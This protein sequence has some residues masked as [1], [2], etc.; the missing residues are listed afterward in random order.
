MPTSTASTTTIAATDTT[1]PATPGKPAFAHIPDQDY[2]VATPLERLKFT[3]YAEAG[4]TV[5]LYDHGNIK[6]GEQQ[7]DIFGRWFIETAKVGEGAHAITMTVTDQ[8]GNVSSHSD[9]R[10]IQ[11]RTHYDTP[12]APPQ[13][14]ALSD[15]GAS[16][17]D[18]ISNSTAPSFIGTAPP[19]TRVQ[20]YV[21]GVLGGSAIVNALGKWTLYDVDMSDGQHS[22]TFVVRD[23]SAITSP[24]SPPLI[25]TVDTSIP[26]ADVPRLAPGTASET[27]DGHEI[28][29]TQTATITGNTEAGAQVKLYLKSFVV[30]TATA[31]ANGDWSVEIAH[32]ND[33]DHR[34]TTQAMDAAGNMDWSPQQALLL[35]VDTGAPKLATPANSGTAGQV[36][37]VT[38]PTVTGTA[39]A[40]A[41]VE[42]YDGATVVGTGVADANGAWSIVASVLSEGQHSLV[43][44]FTNTN[45]QVQQ[46][47]GTLMVTVK[48]T[49]A[50]PSAPT[51]DIR[52][53]SGTSATDN[54]TND[55][56]QLLRGTSEPG[57]YIRVYDG[58][59]AIQWLVADADGNWNSGELVR[60]THGVHQLSVVSTDLAGN[61]SPRS[62]VTTITIDTQAP[63]TPAAPRLDASSD[64]GASQADHLTNI[65][66]PQVTG[67]AEAGATVQLF[68]DGNLVGTT[69]ADGSGAWSITSS[70]L[71]DGQH[72]LTAFASDAAGNISAVSD[73][74]AINIDRIAL[75]APTRLALAPSADG[76]APA[77]GQLTDATPA[78]TGQGP[79]GATV[80]LLDGSVQVGTGVAD[81]AGNWSIV[82]GALAD[83]VHRL[84]ASTVDAA[85]NVSVPSGELL[86]T[87]ATWAAPAA[88]VLAASSDSGRSN[89]DGITH[90]TTPTVNGTTK[91]GASVTLFDGDT[92]VGAAQADAAGAWSITSTALAAGAHN[93]T[94]KVSDSAGNVS[95]AS[96]ALAITID[97][98]GPSAPGAPDLAAGADGGGS[99]VD[100]VTNVALPVVGGKAEAHAS[101]SLYD[102]ATRLGGAIAD[103]DG[104][105]LITSTVALA[106]GVHSLTVKAV[107]VAGNQ[108]AAS[109]ALSVTIDTAALAAPS[110]LDL[111]A[112]SDKGISNTDNVTSVAAPAISGKAAAGSVV[113]VYDGANALGKVVANASGVWSLAAGTLADGVHQLTATATDLAGNVSAPSAALAVTIDTARPDVDQPLLDA[114]SDSGH[115]TTDGITNVTT[116]TLRGTTEAGATV[117]LLDGATQVGSAVADAAGAW[118]ITSKALAAG[119]HNLA[120]KATDIAGNVSITS[121]ALALTIDNRGPTAPTTLDL[122]AGADS[123]SSALDNIT[124][125]TLPVVGGKAEAYAVVALYDGAQLLGNTVADAA[126]NWQIVSTVA[127]ADGARSLTA[128]TTDTAGNV[129]AASVALRVTIDTGAPAAPSAL[130]LAAVSDKGASNTDNVTSVTTPTIGGKAAAGSTVVLFDGAH[131]IGKAVANAAGTW[132]IASPKLEDGEHR[133]TATATDLAGNTSAPSTALSVTIDTDAPMPGIPGLDARSD[134]GLRD[135]ITNINRPTFKGDGEAGT[136]VT[137]FD[138][139]RQV[140]SAVVD[141]GGAWS[142]T[143]T[144]LA[145]G[146]HTMTAKG[147]DAAGNVSVVMPGWELRMSIDTKAPVAPTVLDLVAGADSGASSSDN[148]SAVTLPVLTGKAEGFSTVSVYDGATLLGSAKADSA[149]AWTVATTVALAKGVHNLTA[150]ATDSTGNTSAASAALK[151]TID[152]AATGLTL[153]GGV[154]YDD[155]RLFDTAGAIRVLDFAA[156]QGDRLLLSHEYNGIR[157]DGAADVLALSHVVGKDMVIDLGAGHAVTL[158]GVTT[159]D[160][161]SIG[162][163]G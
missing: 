11:V 51:L 105:W 68:A 121:T 35:R 155:F 158:V 59:V 103:A 87:I 91:A 69:L 134:S 14:L 25:V 114:R 56:I 82:S 67:Q 12:P 104:N 90:A 24:M 5:T 37:N 76:G 3:G 36:T 84:T 94:V 66:T 32:L 93:L 154:S 58:D 45:G 95:A 148:I 23:N 22:I 78:I 96:P 118:S 131:Q 33:G 7:V 98:R 61:V 144:T 126:G 102:G 46:S 136:T 135:H 17:A 125:V 133:L 120:V 139:A 27:A 10:S 72:R 147:T 157:L 141:A 63:Q 160:A 140:G 8:A 116:P 89:T 40:G 163:T 97:N 62:P 52:N 6:I 39:D 65:G 151:L 49:A 71:S 30:G 57:S 83:G 156:F 109:T 92:Q 99:A 54:V 146:A 16:N 149:G 88:P 106:D 4:S 130:D 142:I 107:D 112:A 77:S 138:G 150:K 28:I 80:I 81:A 48:T 159:L 111:A 64:S 127:L 1:A 85:G 153:S 74:L 19:G 9:A 20:L 124:N 161:H 18:N 129:S 50:A 55:T 53:D 73:G 60:L 113:T 38:T 162:F 132:S 100:N 115:S 128:K 145:E 86:V 44:R 29:R 152:P 41:S 117:V 75:A 101:V 26:A 31:D 34:F 123:G 122:A 21:D 143:S 137:L 15:T 2:S 108:S 43:S 119:L 47:G 79:A 70:A 110:A 13:L 42:L